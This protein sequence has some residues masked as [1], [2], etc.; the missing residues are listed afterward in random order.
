M[1][2]D[3]ILQSHLPAP[4]VKQKL[5]AQYF[6]RIRPKRP[7]QLDHELTDFIR[8]LSLL[9][10]NGVPILVALAWLAPRVGGRLGV[11]L[12][13]LNREIELG[14]S[15]EQGL[16]L[17]EQAAGSALAGELVQKVKVSL[18]RGTPLADQLSQLAASAQAQSAARLLRQAGGNET[19]MLIPTI[20]VILPI[21][22]LF[23][24]YPSLSLLS[25]SM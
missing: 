14:A 2:L 5:L 6:G 22:V 23:A 10:R 9:V 3:R 4:K 20:F 17:L 18:E 21:T 12:S 15:L 1:L 25:S 7:S 16:E 11:L 8:A 24:I 13:E 19:K